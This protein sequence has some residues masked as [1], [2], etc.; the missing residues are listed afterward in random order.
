PHAWP[1]KLGSWDAETRADRQAC[2]PPKSALIRR[3]SWRRGRDS[4][5]QR[6]RATA[7]L[8]SENLLCRRLERCESPPRTATRISNP[9]VKRHQVER[10]KLHS[11]EQ[12]GRM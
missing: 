9:P 8:S 6:S 7:A 10:S 12:L 1:A 3:S 11:S 4:N 5:P 2:H